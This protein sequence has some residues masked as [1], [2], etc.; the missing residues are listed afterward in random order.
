MQKKRQIIFRVKNEANRTRE[1][2]KFFA[3]DTVVKVKQKD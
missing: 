3:A 1:P 2:R